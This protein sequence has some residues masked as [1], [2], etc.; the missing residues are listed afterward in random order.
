VAFGGFSLT[1]APKDR[2]FRVH[3]RMALKAECVPFFQRA[4]TPEKYVYTSNLLVRRDAFDSEAFDDAFTG[5]GWEDVEWAM[6]MV[7]RFTVVHVDNPASHLGLDTAANLA[8]KYEQSVGNYARVV[9]LHPEVVS[10]YPSY[11]AAKMLRKLPALGFWRGMFKRTA[12]F[13]LLP[14]KMRAFSLRLY[15]AALYAAAV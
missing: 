5:W 6:R 13:P 14:A 4:L 9:A 1:Q 15:R 3:R 12:L 11:R 8:R 2:K 10:T 7:R